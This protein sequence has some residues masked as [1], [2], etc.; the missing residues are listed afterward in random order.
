MLNEIFKIVL[1]A[2]NF[3]TFIYSF[4]NLHFFQIFS[5]VLIEKQ[6]LFTLSHYLKRLSIILI[7]FFK[8]SLVIV[9]CLHYLMYVYT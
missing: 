4:F 7:N 6:N 2:N 5:S 1:V 9:E 8:G 3:S